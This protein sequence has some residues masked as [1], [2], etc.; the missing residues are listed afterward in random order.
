[1]LVLGLAP[2]THIS[3]SGFVAAHYDHPS[4]LRF[5][6]IESPAVRV[7]ASTAVRGVTITNTWD[8]LAELYIIATDGTR[9]CTLFDYDDVAMA[10]DPERW[11]ECKIR[12]EWEKISPR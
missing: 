6:D 4:G 2:E 8:G 1:M 10:G 11:W 7:F 3:V 12:C 5:P 9:L